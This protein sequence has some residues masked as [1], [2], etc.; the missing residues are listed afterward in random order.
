MY[1]KTKNPGLHIIGREKDC[2]DLFLGGIYLSRRHC[3]ISYDYSKGWILKDTEP[4]HRGTW[5]QKSSRVE[6]IST[7][8]TA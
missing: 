2:A 8:E 7:E 6:Q 4:S 5:I 3:T 1:L